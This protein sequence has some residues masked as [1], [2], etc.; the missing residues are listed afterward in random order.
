[1]ALERVAFL[2]F[3]LLID[4]YRYDL[5]SGNVSENNWNKHWEELREK[6]QK[7]RSPVE[8][9]ETHFDAGA[10][11]HVASDYQYMAYFISHNLEFQLL[12]SLCL[13]AGQYDP[14]NAS[15]P[16]HKCDIEGSLQA[17]KRLRAGLSLGLSKH[18]SET[19]RIMT[20]GETKISA[21]ALLEYFEPLHKF[22]IKENDKN[23]TWDDI[24][25]FV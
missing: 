24:L 10:K 9:N 19:L 5:F 7:I 20:D 22:L 4:L 13:A 6:Y 17:G 25:H 12:K 14:K 18:W 16:L 2:P 1:M 15:K 11:F 21:E 23:S 3:G 8:R